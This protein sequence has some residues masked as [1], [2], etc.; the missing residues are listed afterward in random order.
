MTTHL[1]C[2]RSPRSA[3]LIIFLVLST[4]ERAEDGGEYGEGPR[5]LQLRISKKLV[6]S[7]L[8]CDDDVTLS[9]NELLIMLEKL[10]PLVQRNR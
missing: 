6:A 2:D 7:G 3:H 9:N 1:K 10:E 8:M 4:C 5:H